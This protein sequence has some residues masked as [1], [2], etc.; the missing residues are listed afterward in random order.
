[1]S[2]DFKITPL[3]DVHQGLGAKMVDFGGWNMPVQYTGIIAEHKNTRENVG[4]FDICHMGEFIV[5][6]EESR[7]FLQRVTVNDVARLTIG[8]SHYSLLC[9]QQGGII[10][11]LIVYRIDRIKYMLVVNAGTKDNDWAWLN[12]QNTF[13]VE[14]ED[15]SDHTC[16]LDLQGPK[17]REMLKRLLSYPDLDKLEY[18][19]FI[20]CNIGHLEAIISRTGYTG[21]LGFEIYVTAHEAV[22][23]W[24]LL[25]DQGAAY[26]LKP[27]GLGARDTLRLEMG[28]S[29]YGH[30]LSIEHTPLEAGLDWVVKGDKEDFIGKKALLNKKAKGITQKLVA[31]EM[32]EKA[33][34]RNGCKIMVDNTE[35]GV[36]TS[37][38]YGP[39]VDK[40]IGLGY[41][42]G[43]IMPE[44]IG[45]E[46]RNKVYPARIVSLP[47][48]KKGTVRI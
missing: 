28:Y 11:D 38:S 20:E 22:H 2:A 41:V 5:Q 14:L 30:E 45:I 48:Y 31:F 29:L 43:A 16:K 26:N 47:F 15:V 32:T 10:D 40:F 25:M 12:Q 33:V 35:G 19:H 44:S 9:N 4:L 3:Y 37:G 6:G 7:D 21:E 17:S 18:F 46:V 23:L 34:P 36:V 42:A 27:V 13:G 24:K 1:M 8:Q 39:S